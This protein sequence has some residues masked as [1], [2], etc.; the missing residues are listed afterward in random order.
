[1]KCK[2]CEEL[3]RLRA[4]LSRAEELLKRTALWFEQNEDRLRDAGIGGFKAP[5][6]DTKEN[7]T[8]LQSNKR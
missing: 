4:R 1:M 3:D 7:E 8:V 6:D 2:D 5:N